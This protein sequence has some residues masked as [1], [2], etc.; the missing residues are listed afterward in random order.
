MR[1]TDIAGMIGQPRCGFGD[2]GCLQRR[3]LALRLVLQQSANWE[4]A[5][6]LI[7][8]LRFSASSAITVAAT[9]SVRQRS[10]LA[11]FEVSPPGT[12]KIEPADGLLLHTNHF[13]SPQEGTLDTYRRDWP[14]TVTRLSDL[15]VGLAPHELIEP[16]AIKGALSTHRAGS[17]AVCCHD[18]DN[19]HYLDRQA[20]LASVYMSLDTPTIEVSQGNPCQ[21]PYTS[22][23]VSGV[24]GERI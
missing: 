12:R 13:L 15:Q 24:L 14:D 10:N 2:P 4:D 8:S 18:A 20:T 6:S 16:D 19:P 7:E 3:H 23:N 1:P 22:T 17:I 5:A 9:D 21:A 11:T